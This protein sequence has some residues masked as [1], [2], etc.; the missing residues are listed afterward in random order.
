MSLCE[1]PP[2]R[3]API[4]WEFH[5]NLRFQVGSIVY[6]WG[7]WVDFSA[8]SI[9]RLY[10]LVNDDGEAYTAIFPNMDYQCLMRVLT[11]G[12]GS[13]EVPSIHIKGVDIS[14]EDPHTCRKSLVQFSL[15]Q[16]QA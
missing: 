6:F 1:H 5:S 11:R 16:N 4:I 14:N 9:N 3:I 2:P 13:L 7:K 15:C 8:T 10:N 12:R